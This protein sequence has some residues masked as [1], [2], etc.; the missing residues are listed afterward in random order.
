MNGVI[1]K[2]RTELTNAF[3]QVLDVFTIREDV[4]YYQPAND[5][6]SIHQVLEHLLLANYF[7]LRIINKQTERALQLSDV[8][9]INRTAV[10]QL[11]IAKLK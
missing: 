11:D 5:G 6:W 8:V 7:L 10:Y 1:N 2:I 4:L 9:N 3:N